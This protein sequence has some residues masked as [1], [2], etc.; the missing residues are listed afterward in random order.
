MHCNKCG[1]EVKDQPQ[2]LGKKHLGCG[3][4]KGSGT[5]RKD[6]GRWYLG[7]QQPAQALAPEVAS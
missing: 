6:C 1:K 3:R 5:T 7:K 4:K 2:H